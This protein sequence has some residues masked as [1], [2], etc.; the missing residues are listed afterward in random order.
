MSRTLAPTGQVGLNKTLCWRT[1]ATFVRPLSLRNRRFCDT[2]LTLGAGH[3]E[4]HEEKMGNVSHSGRPIPMEPPRA[5]WS[6]H[7]R[8]ILYTWQLLKSIL[9]Q[10]VQRMAV[11]A[12]VSRNAETA[13]TSRVLASGPTKCARQAAQGQPARRQF[14]EKRAKQAALLLRQARRFPS[15]PT[16]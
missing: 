15:G 7:Q 11:L 8:S 5:P 16:R 9:S 12:N 4:N 2:F 6:P 10:P 3:E 1:G 13:R 14:G